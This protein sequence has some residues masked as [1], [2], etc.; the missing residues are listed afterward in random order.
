MS[1]RRRKGCPAFLDVDD[2]G[3]AGR[4]EAEEIEERGILAE[5]EGI[6]A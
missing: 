3:Q 2:R 1:I 6:R 4:I 5:M